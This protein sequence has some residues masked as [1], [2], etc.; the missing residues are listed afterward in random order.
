MKSR[1]DVIAR[2][3]LAASLARQSPA[4][5]PADPPPSG[6]SLAAA[7]RLALERSRGV[8]AQDAAISAAR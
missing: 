2:A 7:Q 8:A 3:A 6:L 1:F 5:W 4:V